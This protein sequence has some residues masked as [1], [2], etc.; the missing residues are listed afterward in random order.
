MHGAP[1]NP[2][3]LHRSIEFCNVHGTWGRHASKICIE[4]VR[5]YNRDRPEPTRRLGPR[6]VPGSVD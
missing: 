2:M 1:G 4:E 6:L 3:A 5:V